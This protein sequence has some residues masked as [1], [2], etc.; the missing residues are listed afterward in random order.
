MPPLVGRE[1]SVPRARNYT[2]R[3]GVPRRCRVEPIRWS[4]GDEEVRWRNMAA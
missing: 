2:I 3:F 1:G 4:G